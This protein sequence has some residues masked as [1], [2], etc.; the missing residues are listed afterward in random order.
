M[1]I[2]KRERRQVS[3]LDVEDV[4]LGYGPTGGCLAGCASTSNRFPRSPAWLLIVTRA[5]TNP[6]EWPRHK[7]QAAMAPLAASPC[8]AHS[9]RPA[10]VRSI[11]H[12]GS[13]LLETDLEE[14][15]EEGRE[16]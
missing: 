15:G 2:S 5:W 9:A 16:E 6:R 12:S 13:S 10:R 3:N 8:V 14:A 1:D 4:R 11:A 7:R